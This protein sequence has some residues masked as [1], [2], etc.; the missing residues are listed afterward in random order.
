MPISAVDAISP[1]FQ[2]AKQ[3][4]L[5]PFR[6]SQWAR[7]ALLGLGAGELS[8]GGCSTH[9]NL[10]TNPPHGATRE[11]LPTA[12]PS[13]PGLG[14]LS[15]GQLIALASIA[16]LAAFV[17]LVLLIYINS[18]CRFILF[19]SVVGRHC[20]LRQGWTRRRQTGRRFFV[21]QILFQVLLLMGAVVLI[22]IPLGIAY[23]NGWLREPS[24]HLLPLILGGVFLFFIV[25]AFFLSAILVQV[26]A[27]DFLVPLMALEGLD[28]NQAW[29]RLL[30]MLNAEKGSYAG[31]IGM[32]IVLAIAAAIVC[33]IAFLLALL[34]F[35]IPVGVIAAVLIF[36]GKAAGLHLNAFT[37]TLLVI[38]GIVVLALLIYLFALVSV[39][40]VVFFPAY[41]LYFFA[42]RYPM[43]DALLHP[44]PPA[45]PAPPEA[46]PPLPPLPPAP[47]PI[48]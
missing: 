20:Q 28:W 37:I 40:A 32:K 1:A 45:P 9:Y 8:S 42:S 16:V 19:D 30:P 34:I 26:L 24:R 31:Y 11:L 4:L 44:A 41:S 29:Q 2:H 12:L 6:F 23:L 13:L 35:L 7:L 3:Q 38:V 17:L 33:A 15:L 5:H 14:S 22:G 27:K 47:E 18:I 43:L 46:P 25:A 21:W 10:P 48:G 36:G 39:P